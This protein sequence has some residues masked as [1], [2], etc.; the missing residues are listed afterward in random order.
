[1]NQ[2]E[3]F[4]NFFIAMCAKSGSQPEMNK[5]GRQA[6]N[7]TWRRKARNRISP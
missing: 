2:V 4:P 5:A 1:M 3:Q 7:S 6:V